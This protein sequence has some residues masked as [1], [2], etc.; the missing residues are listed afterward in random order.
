MI[1]N[2]LTNLMAM[3]SP[4]VAAKGA[5]GQAA[6][7]AGDFSGLFAQMDM[8]TATSPM[9]L[10]IPASEAS[11]VAG[12]ALP[13][14][15]PPL[16]MV[17]ALADASGDLASTMPAEQA[18]APVPTEQVLQAA[19]PL[20][21]KGQMV[22]PKPIVEAE[23]LPAEDAGDAG[24]DEATDAGT[25]APS[26]QSEAAT[27]V[28]I[29]MMAAAVIPTPAPVAEPTAP[30]RSDKSI[31]TTSPLQAPAPP[32]VSIQP[33]TPAAAGELP[34]ARPVPVTKAT[35]SVEQ[36]SVPQERGLVQAAASLPANTPIKAQIQVAPGAP[37]PASVAPDKAPVQQARA[38]QDVAPIAQPS[39]AAAAVRA[40]MGTPRVTAATPV[41]PQAENGNAISE[42]E[43]LAPATALLRL[44]T[45]E[46]AQPDKGA[47][48]APK[49]MAG[50]SMTDSVHAARPAIARGGGQSAPIEPNIDK[51][52]DKPAPLIDVAASLGVGTTTFQR[53]M[54]TA[55]AAPVADLSASL[56]QQVI[57]LSSSGQWVDG[58]ARE[59]AS[60][61]A[62]TGQGSFRL[63]PPN[64]GPM[65]VAI[66]Q[67]DSGVAIKLT[68]ETMAA[69]TALK[70]DSSQLK[71]DAQLAALRV[72][73]VTVE[74]VHRVHE[75]SATDSSS[76]GNAGQNSQSSF[77]QQ[78]NWGG[79]QAQA[80]LSQGQGQS[81][82]QP[83]RKAF[84]EG[85]V[86]SQGD[87]R[88]Q[89]V[90]AGREDQPRARYA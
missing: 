77:F 4:G 27:P 36:A 47:V 68:V 44:V 24:A 23:N 72:S 51:G 66:S 87:M 58:L 43:P 25:P 48:P 31:A 76:Q 82:G 85:A 64:L 54:A 90:E 46:P 49:L 20:A 86:S 89:G 15:L 18:P 12:A 2:V 61:A 53:A 38:A 63:S 30:R 65:H 17:E 42:A 9:A 34:T 28:Q 83:N 5:G 62:G 8:A 40:V 37:A 35:A 74:R 19:I 70:Q 79:G 50:S 67:G 78:G 1:V 88:D 16:A 21:V 41:P 32:A 45:G 57:D 39:F 73:D 60:M 7:D 75:P 22:R 84:S 14:P 52:S 29:P 56:N 10:A 11:P 33:R 80:A 26:V 3:L 55:P 13:A 81:G 6:A 71:A 69:E 59:I